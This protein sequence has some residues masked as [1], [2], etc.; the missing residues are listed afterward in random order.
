MHVDPVLMAAATGTPGVH[1]GSNAENCT[2]AICA[3][4]SRYSTAVS[5]H[6]QQ[7]IFRFTSCHFQLRAWLKLMFELL[8]LC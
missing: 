7:Y 4:V 1:D 8:N 2:L 3:R 6:I 5:Q